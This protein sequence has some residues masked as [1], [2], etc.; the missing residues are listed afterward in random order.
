[1]SKKTFTKEEINSLLA[2]NNVAN[3]TIKSITYSSEFKVNAIKQYEEG[4]MP[5]EIFINSGFNL[6]VLGKVHPKDCLKRW[7]NI[8]RTKGINSLKK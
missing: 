2:N 7:R 1:M 5:R 8:V 3:C 4:W 6:L